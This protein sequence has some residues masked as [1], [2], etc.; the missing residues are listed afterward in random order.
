[1]K[2]SSFLWRKVLCC[3]QPQLHGCLLLQVQQ[4]DLSLLSLQMESYI[5]WCD[6]G[7]DIHDFYH[8]LCVRSTAPVCSHSGQWIGQRCD[9]CGWGHHGVRPSCPG[10]PSHQM[11]S[12][13]MSCSLALT[14][15]SKTR[16]T[17]SWDTPRYA[18]PLHP[19]SHALARTCNS[20]SELHPVPSTCPV[21]TSTLLLLH[22]PSVL[23]P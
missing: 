17:G 1:M 6:H 23:P 12:S 20:T 22:I 19:H 5:M 11:T 8:I 3:R 16:C 15:V 2:G 10:C 4:E 14:D 21:P 13:W 18:L 9:S 7:R